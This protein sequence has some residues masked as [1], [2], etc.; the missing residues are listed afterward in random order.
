ME[1][2]EAASLL[3]PIAPGFSLLLY[4][5][6]CLPVLPVLP[7]LVVCLIP[8]DGCSVPFLFFPTLC[9]FFLVVYS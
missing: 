1:G 4:G 7:V 5:L 2:L 9:N 3:K 6:S 8:L